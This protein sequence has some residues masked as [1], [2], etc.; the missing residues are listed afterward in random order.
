MGPGCR[1]TEVA[2]L[3]LVLLTEVA[4]LVLVLLLGLTV[5]VSCSSLLSF[6]VLCIGQ[7]ILWSYLEV[8]ILFEQWAGHR[9][10]SGKV[11]ASC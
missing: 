3:V 8:L 4:F 6:L 2:F 1:F 11:T 5:L 9:L 10:L 7:W